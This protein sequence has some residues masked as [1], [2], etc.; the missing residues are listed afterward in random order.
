MNEFTYGR[1]PGTRDWLKKTT[2]GPKTYC[3][4]L[5]KNQQ[6]CSNLAN[7]LPTHGPLIWTKFD[8]DWTKIVD[9]LSLVYLRA[10]GIIFNQS[11]DLVQKMYSGA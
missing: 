7:I 9:F 2:A 3:P 11:Q 8:E 5:I 10:D 4:I 1:I 6:S